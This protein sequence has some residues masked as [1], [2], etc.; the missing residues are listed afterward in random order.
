LT[1]VAT[2]SLSRYSFLHDFTDPGIDTAIEELEATG[3]NMAM[4]YHTARDLLPTNLRRR[5]RFMTGGTHYHQ[6]DRSLH[7]DRAPAPRVDPELGDS[8]PA[9]DVVDAL[10]NRGLRFDAWVVFGH[11]SSVGPQRPDRGLVVSVPE[12]MKAI[13][14]I[15]NVDNDFA[16]PTPI[17]TWQSSA[18][19]RDLDEVIVSPTDD[20]PTHLTHRDG[21]PIEGTPRG[22]RHRPPRDRPPGHHVRSVAVHPHRRG[23]FHRRRRP[24]LLLPA[25][26]SCAS[27]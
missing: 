27:P 10:A 4:V 8:D 1:G 14:A 9:R 17:R 21:H 16:P 6:P 25:E 20:Q 12:P 19:P 3:A 23:R 11:N 5:M 18:P 22:R 13:V 7:P 15:D 24:D 2:P 26:E